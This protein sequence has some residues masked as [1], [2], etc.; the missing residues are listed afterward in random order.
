MHSLFSNRIDAGRMARIVSGGSE[1][2]REGRPDRLERFAQILGECGLLSVQN[3]IQRVQDCLHSKIGHTF[4]RLLVCLREPP[5]HLVPEFKNQA[6]RRCA[7]HDGGGLVVPSY[8]AVEPFCQVRVRRRIES[9]HSGKMS[10]VTSRVARIAA[11]PFERPSTQIRKVKERWIWIVDV[12]APSEEFQFGRGRATES[13]WPARIRGHEAGQ[14][15]LRLLGEEP[16]AGA[17]ARSDAGVAVP[18]QQR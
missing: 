2:V 7:N 17:T 12:V 8:K 13:R 1:M 6:L 11:E 16:T 15:A 10:Q 9:S 4:G 3:P 5:T 18:W 14:V